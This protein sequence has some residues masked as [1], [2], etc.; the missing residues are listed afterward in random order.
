MKIACLKLHILIALFT[1][2]NTIYLHAQIAEEASATT[3]LADYFDEVYGADERLISGP[4]YYG[5]KRGSILG[6]PYFNDE[7]WKTGSITIGET[8]FEDLSLNYDVLINMVIIRFKTISSTD[9]QV[10]VR[11]SKIKNLSIGGQLFVPLPQAADSVLMPL[12]RLMSDGEIQYLVTKRKYLSPSNGSGMKDYLYNERS[13]EYLYHNN[14]LIP[15]RGKRS[16]ISL[17]PELKGELKQ[18]AR[19]KMLRLGPKWYDDRALLVDYSNY[20]LKTRQ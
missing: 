14:E 20:L 8:L 10:A 1:A 6:H 18:Y 17:V 3:I 4:F 12:A 7:E 2:F 16:L 9:Y 13:R 15:F 19:E 5:A 11:C